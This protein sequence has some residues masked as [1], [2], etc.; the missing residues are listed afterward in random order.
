VPIGSLSADPANARL[1]DQRSIDAIANSLKRFGQQKPIVC[2]AAGVTV[3]GA[4]LLA[5]A[6]QL[7]WTHVAAV[8]SQ[9]V[10][11]E[12]VAYGIADNR[13]AEL[14]TWDD[15]ALRALVGSMPEDMAAASGYTQDELQQLLAGD[16]GGGVHQDEIPE[17]AKVAVSKLGDVWIL[18]KHRL[19][20]GDCTEP[21]DVAALMQREKAA[22]F[23]TD[24]PYL[25]DYDGTNHPQS[26][27]SGKSK[28]WSQT[29]G[30]TWDDADGN[31]DLY[32]RF[33]AAAAPH[34]RENAPWYCWHASRRQAMLEAAWVK[35]GAFVHCQIIW[36]KNRPILTR[37]W[38]L[39]QHEPCLMG[40]IKSKK[41]KSIAGVDRQSTVWSVDTIPNGDDR[42]DHPTPKPIELFAIPMQQHT[43]IGEICFEPFS[44]SGTQIIAAEQLGRRCFAIDIQPL[45]IDVAVRRWEALTGKQAV[46]EGTKRTWAQVAKARGVALDRACPQRPS[47]PAESPAAE[48][49]PTK[50]GARPTSKRTSR[51]PGRAQ[52]ARR[53]R[54]DTARSGGR[55]AA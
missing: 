10:G 26:F 9:L 21:A 27:T 23:A 11:A 14:S 38:Y 55:S 46:L 30:T 54:G 15:D 25:V 40:W 33:I 17:P 52:K 5:A 37:T 47:V 44:G 42:P 1:H 49:S 3:A 53:T 51:K 28:D 19:M 36:A 29:Y 35:A 8:R 20:C 32:D 31:T 43:L 45:Y 12:R 6:V 24:P 7:G 4:G 50:A 2:D 22:L 48:T 18:G 41:P 34:L 13:T 16:E 39:W